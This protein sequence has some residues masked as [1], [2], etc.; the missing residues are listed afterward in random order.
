MGFLDK[1]MPKGGLPPELLALLANPA[2]LGEQVKAFYSTARAL[3]DAIAAQKDAVGAAFDDGATP[4]DAAMWE[5]AD[6][7][8]AELDK[9]PPLDGVTK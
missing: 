2:K 3:L 6:A 7:F 1:L 9:L 8:R 4:E 5:A